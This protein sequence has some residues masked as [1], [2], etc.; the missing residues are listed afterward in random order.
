MHASSAIALNTPA[1]TRGIY[2]ARCCWI[3]WLR[4]RNELKILR[5]FSSSERSLTP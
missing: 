2:L 3:C 1:V 5:L 4:L